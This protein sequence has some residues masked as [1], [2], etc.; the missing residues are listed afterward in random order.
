MIQ[1]TENPIPTEEIYSRI[2]REGAGSIVVHIGIVKPLVDD[3]KTKGIRLIPDGDLAGELESIEREVREKW[4]LVD[5]LL[6]RRIGELRVGETVLAAAVSATSRE[7]AFG[8]CREAVENLK[9]K[10]ALRKEE[11]YDG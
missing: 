8:A 9:K 2:S 3:R 6:I 5:V 1:V 10:R 7:A 4:E 11:L